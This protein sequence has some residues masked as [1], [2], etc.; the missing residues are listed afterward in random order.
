MKNEIIHDYVKFEKVFPDADLSVFG[1]I[2]DVKC[3]DVRNNE[4]KCLYCQFY[5]RYVLLTL[6]NG[7]AV[8]VAE[9]DKCKEV[10]EQRIG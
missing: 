1:W 6:K 4:E 8:S 9:L 2:E 10:L 5:G 7:Y 3:F